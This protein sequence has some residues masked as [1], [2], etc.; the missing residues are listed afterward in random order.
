MST[1][2][3]DRYD[4]VDDAGVISYAMLGDRQ[5]EAVEFWG[6]ERDNFWGTVSLA[7]L[8]G[9]V[10]GGPSPQTTR[11][12]SLPLSPEQLLELVVDLSGDLPSPGSLGVRSRL[13][14]LAER[15]WARQC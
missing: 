8:R 5:T 7:A 12:F 14:G 10:Q 13:S 6:G 1:L 9:Y 3:A 2:V 15:L 11:G 4:L